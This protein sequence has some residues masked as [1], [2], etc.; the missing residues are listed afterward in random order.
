MSASSGALLPLGSLGSPCRV[1]T[2]QDWSQRHKFLGEK[3][4][5]NGGYDCEVFSACVLDMVRTCC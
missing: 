4:Q 3:A 5:A 1:Y 2:L